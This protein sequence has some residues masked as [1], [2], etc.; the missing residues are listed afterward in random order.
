[1]QHVAERRNCSIQRFMT[2]LPM[3]RRRITKKRGALHSHAAAAPYVA[4]ELADR[5]G[6]GFDAPKQTRPHPQAGRKRSQ[7]EE[8][9]R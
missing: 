2:I 4:G 7:G 9:D 3:V 8:K 1:M 5:R 6:T